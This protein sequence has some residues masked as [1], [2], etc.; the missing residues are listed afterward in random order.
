MFVVWSQAEVQLKEFNGKELGMFLLGLASVN[1]RPTDEFLEVFMSAILDRLESCSAND[2]ADLLGGL[3]MMCS[4]GSLRLSPQTIVTLS[5]A[6]DSKSP[7]A[8]IKQQLIMKG[9]LKTLVD[10]LSLDSGQFDT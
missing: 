4:L 3:C 7:G 5:R 10:L 2:L 9:S 1:Y 8:G 6:V